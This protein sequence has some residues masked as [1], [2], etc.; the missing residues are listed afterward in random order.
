[1]MS[2]ILSCLCGALVYES[3]FVLINYPKGKRKAAFA[4]RLPEGLVF[5]VAISAGI[6]VREQLGENQH[7]FVAS[8]LAMI[9]ISTLGQILLSCVLKKNAR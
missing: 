2:F 7:P 5:G 1:M 6:L 9:V 8:I 4:S 3:V